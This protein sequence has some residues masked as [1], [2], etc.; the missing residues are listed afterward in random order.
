MSVLQFADNSVEDFFF[1]RM[2]DSLFAHARIFSHATRPH[3][4]SLPLRLPDYTWI[5]NVKE[6]ERQTGQAE[7]TSDLLPDTQ[8]GVKTG[9]KWEQSNGACS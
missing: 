3:H 1:A 7:R 4:V 8:R 6:K 9:D 5:E 2:F